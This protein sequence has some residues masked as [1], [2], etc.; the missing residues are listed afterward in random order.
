MQDRDLNIIRYRSGVMTKIESAEFKHELG[1]DS[2]LRF[3]FNTDE[4]IDNVFQADRESF[5]QDES[6]PTVPGAPLIEEL[7][8]TA[9]P[10]SHHRTI[11][12][13]V[14][15]TA[16]ILALLLFLFSRSGQESAGSSSQPSKQSLP[17]TSS[18]PP[19]IQTPVNTDR[20]VSKQTLPAPAAAKS[21]R[22]EKL[23]LDKGIEPAN[24]YV[25]PKGHA[26]FDK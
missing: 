4:F 1:A 6:I 16:F 22:P 20:S 17:Q 23:D 21:A 9:A 3:A 14:G 2:R 13:I 11:Y 8:A 12:Y 24:M 18:Q 5:E 25:D 7:A 26:H 15:A 10:V 19:V